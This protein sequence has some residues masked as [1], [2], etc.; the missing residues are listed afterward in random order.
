MQLLEKATGEFLNYF[1]A[2]LSSR[3]DSATPFRMDNKDI[4]ELCGD[5]VILR[6]P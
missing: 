4:F 2:G 6:Y 1:Q 5:T 3:L